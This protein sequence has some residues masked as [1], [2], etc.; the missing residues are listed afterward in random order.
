[1]EKGNPIFTLHQA[2]ASATHRDLKDV[3]YETWDHDAARN[4]GMTPLQRAEARSDGTHPKKTAKRRPEIFETHVLMFSQ[5]W[6]STALGYSGLGGSAMT[7]A[8]TVVVQTREEACV[9]FGGGRLAYRVTFD[10]MTTQQREMWE[11]FVSIHDLPGQ[12][13]AK[14]AFN[15]TDIPELM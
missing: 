7:E 12:Q 13:D 11:K 2:L 14:A 3:A 1:M 9:Y 6:G 4:Q 8:Y 5:L 10:N 15:A